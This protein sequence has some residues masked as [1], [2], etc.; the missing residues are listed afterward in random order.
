MI[1]TPAI[2]GKETADVFLIRH[3]FSE[4]NYRD[5]VLRKGGGDITQQLKDLK[6]NPDLCDVNLHAIG[7]HQCLE[8]AS[9]IA[10]INLTRVLVSPMRRA[11]QTTIHMF[12]THPNLAK[13]KFIVVPQAHEIMHTSNDIPIDYNE[14]IREYAPGAA[15]CKGVNFDF[16]WLLHYG[17]P[18]LWSVLS[19]HNVEKQAFV[20]SQLKNNFTYKD[21][22]D[23]W[24][25]SLVAFE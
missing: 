19:L 6:K 2:E 24:I 16:S 1:K 11:L 8:N 15:I 17:E 12:A 22:Q 21:L 14:I 4:F 3:G 9:H 5:L 25:A 7:V 13:I 20:L 18:Q 10:D 23:A